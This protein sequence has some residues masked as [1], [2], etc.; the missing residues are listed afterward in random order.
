MRKIEQQTD[1]QTF[2]LN[3]GEYWR[4]VWRKKYFLLVPLIISGAVSMVGVRFLV[5][6]YESRAVI[7][8]ETASDVSQEMAR[9]V[10]SG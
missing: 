4:I 5:P 7:H 8:I 2:H 6:I 3:L 10:Q 9:F 1:Q